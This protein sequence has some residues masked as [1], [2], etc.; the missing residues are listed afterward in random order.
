MAA[1]SSVEISNMRV[2]SIYA[3]YYKNK[4]MYVTQGKAAVAGIRAMLQKAQ[5]QAQVQVVNP[6][7]PEDDIAAAFRLF[8]MNDKNWLSYMGRKS[9]M[10]GPV[11]LVMTDTMARFI[12]WEAY[13]DI[14][15]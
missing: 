15:T 3:H 10:T 7:V 12:A 5:N 2:W 6:V 9:H 4:R 13:T 14:I 8:L 11:V 1:P